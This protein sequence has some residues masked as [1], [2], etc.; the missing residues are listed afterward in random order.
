M[1]ESSEDPTAWTP[2]RLSVWFPQRTNIA[3]EFISFILRFSPKWYCGSIVISLTSAHIITF[4]SFAWSSLRLELVIYSAVFPCSARKNRLLYLC[5]T[6]LNFSYLT[7]K[8]IWSVWDISGV[9][10]SKIKKYVAPFISF[11]IQFFTF[12]TRR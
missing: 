2:A 7:T 1:S 12:F 4:M 5:F 10:S 8:A 9:L 11:R 3:Y 6:L